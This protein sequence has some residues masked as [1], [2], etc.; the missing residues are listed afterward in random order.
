MPD[1]SP[2]TVERL[3]QSPVLQ[4]EV[5]AGTSGLGRRVAWAHVSELEDPTPWLTGA[6]LIMTTGLGFPR[7]ATQQRDY[8]RRLDDGGV[9]ALAVTTH[10]H[11]PPITRTALLEAERRGFPILE[12]PLS[13]PF[14]AIAQ[15]V[16]AGVQADS[17]QR[18]NAQLQVFGAVRWL[19]SGELDDA[20]VFGRLG[21]LS[22]LRLYLCSVTGKPLIPGVPPPPPELE[23]LLPSSVDVPPTVPGGFVL[24]I[25][26]AGGP[27]G[28]LLAMEMAGI[29]NAGL[30]VVQHIATVVALRLTMRRYGEEIIRREGAE[31]FADLLQG[32]HTTETMTRRLG[33][34]GFRHDSRLQLVVIKNDVGAVGDGRVAEALLEA[35]LPHLLLN[36]GDA[37]YLLMRSGP[38]A[39]AL[40]ATMPEL[41]AGASR[42]FTVGTRLGLP[43]R[44]AL[45]ASARADDA[46]LSFVRYGSD[47]IGR[48]TVED[49]ASLR[50]L[51]ASVLGAAQAYDRDHD[52]D[53]VRTVQ[54]WLER[55]RQNGP[56][57]DVLH[58]HAN[59]LAYRLRR[60]EEISHRNLRSTADLAELWLALRALGHLEVERP[61]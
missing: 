24:P 5:L 18:L 54:T 46:G 59:T 37:T 30:A 9:A 23:R 4:L 56:T 55:E 34:A 11:M 53:L 8:L 17:I 14:I 48:W 20:E 19:T 32:D 38:Q 28:F 39:R 31:T 61:S 27:A 21:R 15:E 2:L 51:V 50:A 44:E 10:L 43:R 45:W 49:A 13:V 25:P 35:G 40:L 41:R 1:S 12:V 22:G 6:E 7:T 33:R 60:F 16:A 57:A 36:S 42:P 26:L 47:T 58:I 3:L 52:S 29:A